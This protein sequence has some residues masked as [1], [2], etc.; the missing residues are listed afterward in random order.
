M[1][2]LAPL[3]SPYDFDQYKS[4]SRASHSSRAPSHDHLMGTTVQSTDVLSRVIWGAQTELKVVIL[5]LAF[6]LTVGV[7][8]GLLS[9]FFGGKL[10]RGLVLVMDALFAFPYLLLAIVIAFLLSNS[11]GKG[12]LTAAIAITAVYVP[13]YFRVVRNH[14][15]A[16][17]EESVRRGGAGARRAS[18]SRSSASTSSSTSS[19]TSRRSRR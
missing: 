12:V 2:I 11:I 7:P 15:I 16:L 6:S 17:R 13:H 3:I 19:R 4:G 9:G 1:A 8:L 18:R 14:V 5:S 10:D